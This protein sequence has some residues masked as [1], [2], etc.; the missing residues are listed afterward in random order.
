MHKKADIILGWEIEDLEY[1]IQNG[2]NNYIEIINKDYGDSKDRIRG[3]MEQAQASFRFYRRS[4][5][6]ELNALI[7]NWL[8]I[9]SSDDGAF[10]DA[11][12]LKRSRSDSVKI[13]NTKYQIPLKAISGFEEIELINEIVNSLK[14]RGGYSFPDNSNAFVEFK[15]VED[16]IEHILYLKESA[17]KFIKELISA[18][19]ITE[20]E[21][22]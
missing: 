6:Y 10:F 20:N 12:I 4:I 13:I 19:I 21:N 3:E 18:I 11:N 9:A 14:H 7:E 8:L 22:I 2:F 5:L 17:F 15:S 16:S 1:Y